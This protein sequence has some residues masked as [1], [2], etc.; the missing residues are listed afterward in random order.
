[1]SP[2]KEALALEKPVNPYQHC[3]YRIDEYLLL[4]LPFS[5]MFIQSKPMKWIT[6]AA[7]GSY[8]GFKGI[9]GLADYVGYKTALR[10]YPQL[11]SFAP[12]PSLFRRWN[13]LQTESVLSS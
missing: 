2:D 5:T 11:F 8:N 13:P 4:F 9:K 12:A 1:M 7:S 3:L 6:L 10:E